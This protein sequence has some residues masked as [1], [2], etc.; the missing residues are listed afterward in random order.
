MCWKAL[1]IKIDLEPEAGGPIPSA[2]FH[3]AFFFA[4]R[5]II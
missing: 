3:F 4:A 1:G 5:N 2:S